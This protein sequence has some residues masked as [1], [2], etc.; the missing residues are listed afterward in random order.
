MKFSESISN[1]SSALCLFQSIVE[2]PKKNSENP[3]FRSKYADLDEIINTIRPALEKTGLAF[4]QNPVKDESGNIGVYTILLHKSGEFIQFDPVFIPVGKATPH[5]VGAALTYARRYSLAAALGIAV[6][7]D[8]DGNSLQQEFDE[9][10]HQT[11]RQTNIG[12]QKKRFFAIAAKR[13]LSEKAQKAVVYFFTEKTSR[14]QVTEEEYRDIS[15]FLEKATI[16]EINEIILTAVKKAQKE[17][18]AS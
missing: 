17:E 3:H 14:K 12:K 13:G 11:N 18:V 1:I 5:Q 2:N 10:Q 6:D 16:D 15:D 9:E 4:I 7:D 8:D